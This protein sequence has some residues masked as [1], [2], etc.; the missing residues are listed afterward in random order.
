MPIRQRL[1]WRLLSAVLLTSA[2]GNAD[3]RPPPL[4]EAEVK[5]GLVFNF[6][7]YVD[8]PGSSFGSA[9][10]PFVICLVG[11]D[12][13]APAFSALSG[14]T[15]K[16][17]VV[18][19]RLGVLPDQNAGCHVAFLAEVPVHGMAAAAYALAAQ[20]VLTVSDA[21]GFID[22]GGA[23]GIV[24]GAERLQFEINRDALDRAGLQASSQLLKLARSLIG[25]GR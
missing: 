11:H 13:F 19:V 20:G 8:W 7:R 10:A 6:A 1:P 17:R 25:R 3:A 23:I 16:G 15:L 4:S 12:R 2:L 22:S 9:D 21:D 18:Q 24:P 14:R 5:A